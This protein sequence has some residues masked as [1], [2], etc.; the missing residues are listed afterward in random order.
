MSEVKASFD[1]TPIAVMP[2]PVPFDRS[3]NSRVRLQLRLHDPR[4]HLL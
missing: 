1:V 2:N 3:P 4:D